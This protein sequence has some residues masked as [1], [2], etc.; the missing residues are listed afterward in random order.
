MKTVLVVEDDVHLRRV[1]RALLEAEGF[2]V[3]E[4]PDGIEGL[5]AALQDDPACII[6]DTMMPRMDG[7]AMLERLRQL[8][9][10]RPA[11]IV[12]AVHEHPVQE[13]L[14]ALGVRR[15]FGKPFAFDELVAEVV[16]LIGR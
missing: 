15:V 9:K 8:G 3:A 16:R 4:A 1:F 11:L 2:A 12:S 14:A 7:I 10:T 5:A 13:D 6:T